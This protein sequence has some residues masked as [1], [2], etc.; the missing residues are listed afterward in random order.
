MLDRI[1]AML[2]AGAAA[3]FV[4]LAIGRAC[5]VRRRLRLLNPLHGVRAMSAASRSRG[6]VDAA[7][8]GVQ[9]RPARRPEERREWF[10]WVLP[11][12][13]AGRFAAV[14]H[15]GRG[16]V[17]DTVTGHVLWEGEIEDSRSLPQSMDEIAG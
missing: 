14:G 10:G 7:V 2:F 15:A 5:S 9:S 3:Y 1:D 6:G 4:A 16:Y 8:E 11:E 17:V 12:Q 13:P